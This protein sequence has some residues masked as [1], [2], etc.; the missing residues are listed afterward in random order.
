MNA[1]RPTDCGGQLDIVFM[2][3]RKLYLSQEDW[4]RTQNGLVSI[5]TKI[6]NAYDISNP[7]THVGFGYYD[8]QGTIS[9]SL[10]QGTNL[11]SVISAIRRL[12]Y[13][14]VDQQISNLKDGLRV[15]GFFFLSVVSLLKSLKKFQNFYMYSPTFNLFFVF[16]FS[17]AI[18]NSWQSNAY[19]D[20]LHGCTNTTGGG[21]RFRVI[22]A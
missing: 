6:N 1:N 5:I 14:E 4:S 21:K 16:L 10:N 8:S 7:R 2:L 22:L 17:I 12:P 11:G 3:D 15:R 20:E 13:T 9:L 18:V 19:L